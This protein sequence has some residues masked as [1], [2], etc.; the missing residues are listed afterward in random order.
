[1]GQLNIQQQVSGSIGAVTEYLTASF[2]MPITH[3]TKTNVAVSN[4]YA[5]VA[6][7]VEN[8]SP[9]VVFLNNIGTEDAI[10]RITS[11]SVYHILDLPAGAFVVLHLSRSLA[12]GDGTG[13]KTVSVYS[14]NG[15]TIEVAVFY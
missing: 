8:K 15:T 6:E 12:V 5:V 9:M 1:M 13:D 14:A 11:G 4:T 3:G 2:N 7:L 10:Y